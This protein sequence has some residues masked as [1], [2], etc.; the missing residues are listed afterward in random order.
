MPWSTVLSLGPAIEGAQPM[1]AIIVEERDRQ[2]LR[3]ALWT[4]D[5]RVRW[6]A[7]LAWDR[8]LG[9]GSRSA[10]IAR[11]RRLARDA[12]KCAVA[13]AD[14]DAMPRVDFGLAWVGSK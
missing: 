6:I 13:G 14:V 4:P 7:A 11:A 9:A 3:I 12:M 2:R 5:D 8:V 10:A 1:R